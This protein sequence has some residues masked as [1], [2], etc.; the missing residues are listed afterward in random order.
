MGILLGHS[1]LFLKGYGNR[2]RCQRTGRIQILLQSSKVARIYRHKEKIFYRESGEALEQ[3]A[4][5]CDW[6][7]ILGDFQDKAG[8]GPGQPGLAVDLP[9]HCRGVGLDGLLSF[10]PTLR[11]L[12]F[13]E[14]GRSGEL[15]AS[16]PH[17][18]PWKQKQLLL[19]ATSNHIEVKKVI[20][21]TQ[22]RFTE[23]NHA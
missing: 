23:G 1:W 14:G 9:V 15:Q 5:W 21:K 13:Y 3:V 4:Q 11:I 16:Q 19:K 12:W 22:H 8:S 2:E 18:S 10:L 20:R 17:L 7:P 6:C